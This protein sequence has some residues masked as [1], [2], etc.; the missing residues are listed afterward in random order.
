MSRIRLFQSL[1]V[2]LALSLLT[3]VVASARTNTWYV[4]HGG[5]GNGSNPLRPTGSLA[6]AQSRSGP[7]DII[8]VLP[9]SAPLDG[10]ITLQDG[11]TLVGLGIGGHTPVI[12]NSNPSS[13]GGNGV[14]LANDVRVWNLVIQDTARSGIYGLDST[15]SDIRNVDVK[16]A[17]F[18]GSLTPYSSLVIGPVPHGGIILVSATPG[19]SGEHRISFCKVTDAVAMSVG[20]FAFYGA[21]TELEV[22][23]SLLS[24]GIGIPPDSP[25]IDVGL[26]GVAEFPGSRVE[27]TLTHS[28]VEKRLTYNGRNV[29]AY[30]GADADT[31]LSVIGST[32]S[33]SGQDGVIGI[34]ALHPARVSV[35]IRSSLVERSAQLN[36]EG[37][38]INTP[39]FDPSRADQSIVSV[40][41]RDSTIR[42][43][44]EYEGLESANVGM[45]PS[46]FVPAPFTNGTYAL[47]IENSLLEDSSSTGV[48]I[49]G[50]FAAL[51]PDES[52]YDV[53][54]SR[55]ILLDEPIAITIA[56]TGAYIDA[57]R[58][59]WGTP[60]GLTPDRLEL[61]GGATSDQIDASRPIRCRAH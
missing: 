18:T 11:Q 61:I 54:L 35:D 50:N 44:G 15:G 26:A 28:T 8:F 60:E 38:L 23:H 46:V 31:E 2:A 43:P 5:T 41:V 4:R 30:A 20:A 13:N 42:A 19:A 40:S 36:V 56:A 49:G 27:V 22:R 3:P 52:V 37:T 34:A 10:G 25:M 59:C 45:V 16:R 55:N 24:G 12:S 32:V 6:D 58:N 29:L 57:R 33:E 48:R 14:V 21:S 1:G 53:E 39:P 7:S 9:G 47:S 51:P 17:N